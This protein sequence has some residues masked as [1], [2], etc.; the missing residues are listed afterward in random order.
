[1]AILLANFEGDSLSNEH[2]KM[3]IKWENENRMKDQE[4][5]KKQM[6]EE[7]KKEKA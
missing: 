4:I 1:L 7:K 6:T 3:I 5:A 2:E